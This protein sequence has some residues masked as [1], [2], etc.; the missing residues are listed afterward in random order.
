MRNLLRGFA[1]AALSVTPW[2]AL[3]ADLP[4]HKAPPAPPPAFTWAGPYVGLHGGYAWS[5]RGAKVLAVTREQ[6]ALPAEGGAELPVEAPVETLALTPQ[7][8]ALDWAAPGS[9]VLNQSGFV[10]GGQVGYAWQFGR[11]VVGP[12]LD[13]GGLAGSNKTA[14]FA[15]SGLGTI[16]AV[17]QIGRAWDWAGLADAR[18]GFAATPELLV[19]AK[20][21][22]AFA[23]TTDSVVSYS[24]PW[25][26]V[27][28]S[29]TGGKIL[30]G[31]NIGGGVEWAFTTIPGWSVKAE[32]N[33]VD[34]GT[35]TASIAG[36]L[37]GNAPAT[38]QFLVQTKAQEN[39]VKVGVNWHL[40]GLGL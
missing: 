1:I 13:F 7:W 11:L 25:A 14:T 5:A 33:Y 31:W 38:Q 17:A 15:V 10:G 27:T 24:A 22:F 37:Y 35:R 29:G 18:V 16:P 4:T 28:S 21:G 36:V 19:Y 9:A 3:A 26:A 2:A 32:Y 20:G 40:S 30:T 39:I 12:E 8:T 34:L 6:M 23:H